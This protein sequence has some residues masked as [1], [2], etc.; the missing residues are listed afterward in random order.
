MATDFAQI[1]KEN[2][3]F[4][5]MVNHMELKQTPDGKLVLEEKGQGLSADAP[6]PIMAVVK[7]TERGYELRNPANDEYMS[8]FFKYETGGLTYTGYEVFIPN[9]NM[10]GENQKDLFKYFSANNAYGSKKLPFSERDADFVSLVGATVTDKDGKVVSDMYGF[11]HYDKTMKVL[12]STG[13]DIADAGNPKYFEIAGE[14]VPGVTSNITTT[15]LTKANADAMKAVIEKAGGA[16]LYGEKETTFGKEQSETGGGVSESSGSGPKSGEVY[17]TTHPGSPLFLI[18]DGATSGKFDVIPVKIKSG[19]SGYEFDASRTPETAYAVPANFLSLSIGRDPT[20]LTDAS[21]SDA[22]TAAT[23]AKT[24]LTPSVAITA[25]SDARH[26]TAVADGATSNDGKLYL[27]FNMNYWS[28]DFA[29]GDITVTGGTLSNFTGA[30][31]EYTAEFTP[32][33][34]SKIDTTV[35]VAKDKFTNGYKFS[36]TAANEFNWT[37]DPIDIKGPVFTDFSIKTAK[38]SLGEKITIEFKATDDTHVGYFNASFSSVDDPNKKINIKAQNKANTEKLS[39]HFDFSLNS[40]NFYEVSIPLI[41]DGELKGGNYKL[42]SFSASDAKTT[43][44][45]NI[46]NESKYGSSV[47]SADNAKFFKDLSNTDLVVTIPVLESNPGLAIINEQESNAT[48]ERANSILPDKLVKG[49][50]FPDGEDWFKFDLTKSG[51]IVAQMDMG[52]RSADLKLYGP[53]KKEIVSKEVVKSGMIHHTA[54]DLGEYYIL[55][56]DG[57][58]NNSAYELVLDIV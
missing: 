47:T 51:T 30:R 21:N 14:F 52:T 25:F 54:S 48:L 16:V 36:N 57:N 23:A 9:R 53:D 3:L 40:N 42:D 56:T 24:A 29:V 2:P 13:I 45:P 11:S 19:G 50:V 22:S 18:V 58:I 4:K 37:Y 20:K 27:K 32:S 55:V 38:P 33:G 39:D 46:N 43:K 49:T 17:E 8:G 15:A 1:I 44:N 7:V 41:I 28:T 34:S 31:N 5:D 6:K 10:L 35:N 12:G 26:S